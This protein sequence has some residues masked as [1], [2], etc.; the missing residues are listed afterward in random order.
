MRT[1]VK[2]GIALG[3]IVL[4]VA[5]SYYGSSSEPDIEL[6]DSSASIR[7]SNTQTLRQLLEPRGKPKASSASDDQSAELQAKLAQPPPRKT[8]KPQEQTTKASTDQPETSGVDASLLEQAL[9]QSKQL[10]AQ[11][12]QERTVSPWRTKLQDERSVATNDSESVEATVPARRG[13]RNR[14]WTP[15]GGGLASRSESQ[16]QRSQALPQSPSKIRPPT[17]THV[18]QPGDNFS[19][20]AER[21]YGSQR[22]T[23]FLMNANPAVDPRRMKV[24]SIVTIPQLVEGQP[25]AAQRTAKYQYEVR[26][27]DSLYAIAQVQLGAGDRWTEI[28]QLNRGVIGAS[29][30]SLDVGLILRLPQR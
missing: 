17:G 20:L 24:G 16:P 29:P 6:A 3:A 25:S 18:I 7:E 28:Y 4:I 8:I 15:R 10:P 30:S 26:E 22:Y 23:G 21:Y 14:A 27:G 19:A 2:V 5:G 11:Q 9:R 1:D 13:V 12:A